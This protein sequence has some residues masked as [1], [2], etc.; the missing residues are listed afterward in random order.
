MIGNAEKKANGGE[1]DLNRVLE[2]TELL[3]NKVRL[4]IKY[5]AVVRLKRMKLLSEVT[6]AAMGNTGGEVAPTPL[7]RKLVASV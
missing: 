7:V 5:S 3:E 2:M 1:R 4:I 6:A